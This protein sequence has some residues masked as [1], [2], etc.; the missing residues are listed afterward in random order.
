MRKKALVILLIIVAIIV[1]SVIAIVSIVKKNSGVIV[2]ENGVTTLLPDENGQ[3]TVLTML[4]KDGMTELEV[5][6]ECAA[7]IDACALEVYAEDNKE[8]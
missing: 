3:H 1:A 2:D 4:K 7:Y 5:K 8:I 6:A